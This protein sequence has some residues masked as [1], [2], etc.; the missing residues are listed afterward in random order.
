MGYAL[1]AIKMGMIALAAAVLLGGSAG[2]LDLNDI[3]ADCHDGWEDG[4]AFRF[5]QATVGQQG[6]ACG[7]N[8][9]CTITVDVYTIDPS[10]ISETNDGT[11]TTPTSFN[12]PVDF[13]I[14]PVDIDEID[15]CF[16]KDNPTL[17][18][19]AAVKRSCP[20]THTSSTDPY[21]DGLD[22]RG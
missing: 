6:N 4:D 21:S 14:S 22:S 17:V 8:G 13:V 9:A 19:T 7:A 16:T 18:W 1:G 2:A 20:T 12:A 10:T 3:R 11:V 5:C 15:I